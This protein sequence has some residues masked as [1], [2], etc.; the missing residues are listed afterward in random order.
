M[1]DFELAKIYGYE[2]AC[3]FNEPTNLSLGAN[4]AGFLKVKDAMIKE[5]LV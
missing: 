1:L 4:I 3:R 2:T 5:G